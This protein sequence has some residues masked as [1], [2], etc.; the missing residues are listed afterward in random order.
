SGLVLM[1]DRIVDWLTERYKR[2]LRWS[3]GHRVLTLGIGFASLV[4]MALFYRALEKE[5]LPEEDK[6]RLFAFIVGPLG[7]TPAYMDRM[8]HK[9]E[10][11]VGETPEVQS[12][13]CVIA[14]SFS[15]PGE[16]NNGIVFIR[17]KDDRKRSV[18][19]IVSGPDGLR[20]KFFNNV[21]GAIAIAQIPK[22]IDRS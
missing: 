3:L 2:I 4:F 21:E 22:A 7:S 15:G 18:Q 19:E 1:F 13:G 10:K 11:L 12:F 5:F 17:L 8:M 14:P 20:A 9:V 6:G 16:A